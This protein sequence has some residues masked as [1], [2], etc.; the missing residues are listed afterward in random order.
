MNNL[1]NKLIV[2]ISILVV[3]LC[4]SC[5]SSELKDD[6]LSSFMLGGIYFMHGYGGVEN[7]KKMI[8]DAGYTSNSDIVSGYKEIFEFPFDS[9][10]KI[11]L[12]KVLKDWWEITDKASLLKE[13]EILKTRDYKYK[14]WDYARI[15]NN[16]AIG[17]GAGYLTKEEVIDII[18]E[19]LPLARKDYKN[20]DEYHK[21]FNLGRADWDS[22]AEQSEEYE[23]IANNIT[24]GD[25]SIYKILPL[26]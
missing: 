21:D 16:A 11:Q 2:T 20:W 6:Q 3:L 24:K 23:N 5:G 13:T 9:S 15:V 18:T 10:Q 7:T 17:Y 1:K 25:D 19:I 26:N 14:S 12:I 22:E 4:K 8:S